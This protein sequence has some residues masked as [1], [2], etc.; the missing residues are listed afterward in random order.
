[1]GINIAIKEAYDEAIAENTGE[2]ASYIPELAK[3]DTELFSISIC[4]TNGQQYSIGHSQQSFTLQSISKVPAYALALESYM[5]VDILKKVGVEPTGDVFNSI[6]K[7][8]RYQRPFN[9]MINAGAIAITDLIISKFKDKALNES[10]KFFSKFLDKEKVS[11][12]EQVFQSEY[13]TGERN[14]SL[15]HLLKSFGILE[16]PVDDVLELYFKH[17]AIEATTEDLA[18]MGAILAHRGCNSAGQNLIRKD[19][20][21]KLLSVMLSCGMYNYAGQWIYEVGIPAKSG[22]SG[23]ILAVVPD[24][25]GIAVYSPRINEDGCSNRGAFA[26]KCLCKKLKLHTFDC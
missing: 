21:R 22:V 2:V 24:K 4:D 20:L 9:P 23:G 17:C 13:E 8:D 14:R 26:L 5:D 10:L 3:I 25:F 11:V 18:H 15:A 12:N 1:M 16:N 19:N 6:I 7:L